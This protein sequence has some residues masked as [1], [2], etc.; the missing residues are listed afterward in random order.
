MIYLDNG[1][2]TR[3]RDGVL[4]AML[5]YLKEE[6]EN[7]FG[8]SA[9][10][11]SCGAAVEKA[12]R[13]IAALVNADYKEIYFTSGGTESDNWVLKQLLD[14]EKIREDGRGNG[15]FSGHL[16]VSAVEHH[17]VL[18]PAEFLA[19]LGFD[20]TIVPVD[21]N[22]RVDP[23]EV[24]KAV[25]EDTRLV[26]VMLANNEIGTIEP[27][28]EIADIAHEA[29]ALMHTDAVQAVG[30]IP[31]DVKA[32]NV[33]FLS[34]SGHKFGGPKGTG[35]LY[36]RR[37]LLPEPLMH[38]GAQERGL[39]AGT[40]NVPGISGMGMAAELAAQ[41]MDEER[42]Y[43]QNLR[44]Y[45]TKRILQEIPGSSLNGDPVNRL[46]GNCNVTLPG[47]DNEM[48]L[49]R[50][51]QEGICAAAGSACSAGASE[52]SHVLKAIGRTDEEAG[53]SFRFTLNY[54]NTKDE[55]DKS[56]DV[57]KKIAEECRKEQ[58]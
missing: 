18:K 55:I 12:R 52:A 49:V 22:G 2:T 16:I 51:D 28:R 26:S 21:E 13:R 35:F 9:L 14:P 8:R 10:N 56:C 58:K 32:L 24:R 7:P 42:H 20:L 48:A 6:Y 19:K 50:L 47:V 57:L 27:V 43:E 41:N 37:G 40:H 46:P 44:D 4:E 15:Q 33:D 29:G 36:I 39:R 34:A 38:G 3:M 1:A 53:C 30:H 5:P 25:R 31:V 45:M 54:R 11:R 23:E 17:A